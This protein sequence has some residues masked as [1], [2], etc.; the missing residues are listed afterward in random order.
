MVEV[1]EIGIVRE[2][3][4]TME[5]PFV[6]AFLFVSKQ[7]NSGYFYNFCESMVVVCM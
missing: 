2:G 4:Y 7:I 1:A 5:F 6:F 3:L